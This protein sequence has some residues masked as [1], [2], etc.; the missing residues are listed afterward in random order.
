MAHPDDTTGNGPR[1]AQRIK[2]RRY[3]QL[4][5]L[6][7]FVAMLVVTGTA[8][9]YTGVLRSDDTSHRAAARG[10]TVSSPPTA[11]DIAACRSPLGATAPLRLW[12][13]GDS[14]AG[15]LGPSLG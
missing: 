15:S 8:F 9:A 4:R 1:R 2:R 7:V 10:T 6:L 5:L 11:G 13:G 12:I 3:W 14:L